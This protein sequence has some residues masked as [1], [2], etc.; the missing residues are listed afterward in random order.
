MN[1]TAIKTRT[2]PNKS[3]TIESPVAPI[4]SA[5]YT[6]LVAPAK[7]PITIGIEQKYTILISESP[8]RINGPEDI[9]PLNI[10]T[11]KPVPLISRVSM[12]VNPSIMGV[13]M[14]PPPTPAI[15]A[16]TAMA[17]LNKKETIIIPIINDELKTSVDGMFE[18][19]PMQMYAIVIRITRRLNSGIAVTNDFSL[20]RIFTPNY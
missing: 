1:M 11:T 2:S 3:L 18:N 10:A 7:A 4:T 8:V 16:I 6:A 9:R 14:T 19:I 12:E 5:R 17:V 15:T 13:N 20:E